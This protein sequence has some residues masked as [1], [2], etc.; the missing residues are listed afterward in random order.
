MVPLIEYA[1]MRLKASNEAR[2]AEG[3]AVNPGWEYA[4]SVMKNLGA[5]DLVGAGIARERQE[6]DRYT[7]QQNSE[8]YR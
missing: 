4:A 8:A 3:Q 7:Q 5:V 1:G 2:R 6:H